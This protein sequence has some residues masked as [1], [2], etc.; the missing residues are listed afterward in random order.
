[1]Y[2]STYKDIRKYVE[3]T[4]NITIETCWIAHMKEKC[5]LPTR[6]APNRISQDSRVKPCPPESEKYIKDAFKHFG[7]I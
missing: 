6:P 2:M 1:M 3:E 7:M 5:G 4:Y